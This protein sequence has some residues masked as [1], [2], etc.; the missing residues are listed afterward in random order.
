MIITA[1]G[2][3]VPR[4]GAERLAAERETGQLEEAEAVEDSPALGDMAADLVEDVQEEAKVQ[5]RRAP[6]EPTREERMHHEA[7]H[8]PSR[9]WCPT[10]VRG[11][12]HNAPHRRVVEREQD[13]Y[14]HT[15]P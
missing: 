12:G 7:T 9:C 1:E 2:E 4:G 11:R 13:I 15:A 5:V 8:L 10:C 14:S 3:V 6:K